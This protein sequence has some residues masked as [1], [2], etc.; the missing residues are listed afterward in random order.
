[1]AVLTAEAYLLVLDVRRRRRAAGT[2]LADSFVAAAARLLSHAALAL[3]IALFSLI[4]C[5]MFY[6]ARHFHGRGETYFAVAMGFVIF[7]A[8][9]AAWFCLWLTAARKDVAA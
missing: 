2:G 6:T 8:P 7:Q 1:V 4:C 3:C 5:E 9:L